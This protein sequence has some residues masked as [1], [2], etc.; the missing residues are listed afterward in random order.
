MWEASVKATEADKPVKVF[1]RLHSEQG[2]FLQLFFDEGFG[3]GAEE[4]VEVQT[5][6]VSV[7]SGLMLFD[8]I[9]SCTLFDIGMCCVVHCEV[10]GELSE[11]SPHGG[12]Y[13]LAGSM[14]SAES[15]AVLRDLVG[16]I[17][18]G[19]TTF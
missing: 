15:S 3:A 2:K 13:C 10:I 5:E 8:G 19:H 12:L 1:F 4:I 9:D 6:K 18:L 7:F 11:H 17:V 16:L 14:D